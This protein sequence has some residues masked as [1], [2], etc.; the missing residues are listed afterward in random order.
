MR[1]LFDSNF[2][3]NSALTVFLCMLIKKIIYIYADLK[4]VNKIMINQY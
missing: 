2:F 1:K 4:N 3:E